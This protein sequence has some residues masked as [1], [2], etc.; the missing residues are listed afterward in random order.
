[1]DFEQIALRHIRLEL[2]SPFE[3]SFGAIKERNLL[4]LE[5]KKDG[6][7]FYG[8][9]SPLQEPLYNHETTFTAEEIISRYVIDA[10]KEASS[11]EEYHEKIS[12]IKG[13]RLAKASGD[14][15]LYHFRSVKEGKPISDLVGGTQSHAECGISIGLTRYNEIV[16]KV[17]KFVDKGYQR[18]KLKIKP[19]N[20]IGYVKTVRDKFPEL[21]IMADANSAYTL[22][23]IDRLRK[24]DQYNL[25]MIEQPLGDRDIV[26][27]RTLNEKI[28]TS[29]C[30]DESI[31]SAED[32]KRAVKINAADIINL[33][34]Q[35]VSGL[36][37]SRKINKV[38]KENSMEMWIGGLV[39]SGIGQSSAVI[40]SSL[41]EVSYPGDIAS[42]QK[43]FYN[44]VIQPEIEV[45]NGRVK[46]PEEPG[47]VGK[48]DRGKLEEKTVDRQ[49]F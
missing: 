5:A 2:R 16:E 47:F 37:E 3:T 43:Y 31:H 33:K 24:L 48:V 46:V 15:L 4:I 42:S 34:P 26:N 7:W 10:V 35:R 1:M 39:E 40:A 18:V 28:E 19:G 17:Q 6:E 13:H 8:E 25:S 9:T 12:S 14:Q 27:H 49:E 22:D 36:Y 21:E 29:I 11:I 30:L 23:D 38:C 41:S 45:T 20:D 32:V 44:D